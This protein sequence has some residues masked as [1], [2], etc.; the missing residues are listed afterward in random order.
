MNSRKFLLRL[1]LIGFVLIVGCA[2]SPEEDASAYF[3]QGV[4]N[5]EAGDFE[6][7]IENYSKAIELDPSHAQAYSYRGGAYVFSGEYE[8]AKQDSECVN[9]N[10][11]QKSII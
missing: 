5:A 4:A 6:Q 2:G 1:L 11:T 10:G 8:L 3:K 9:R 7:A